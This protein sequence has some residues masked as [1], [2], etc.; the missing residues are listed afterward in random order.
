M[1]SIAVRKSKIE[2]EK[3]SWTVKENNVILKYLAS[4]FLFM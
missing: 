3:F 2:E 1:A 4:L